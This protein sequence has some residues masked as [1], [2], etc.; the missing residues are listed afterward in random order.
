MNKISRKTL[1]R[2]STTRRYIPE[3]KGNYNQQF[4]R[5]GRRGPFLA[6][7][8][9]SR[10]QYQDWK[11]NNAETSVKTFKVQTGKT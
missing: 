10:E 2:I 6:S 11:G 8:G 4:G 5:R 3:Y 1:S 7:R 9:Y